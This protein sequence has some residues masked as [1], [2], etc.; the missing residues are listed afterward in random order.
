MKK[1]SINKGSYP[2]L[3]S[4]CKNFG[5]L[6][7]WVEHEG[8]R[9]NLFVTSIT[10]N[11]RP[12]DADEESLLDRL[13]MSEVI[14]LDVQLQSIEELVVA[15]LENTIQLIQNLQLKAG[16]LARYIADNGDFQ[17][18]SL[19]EIFSL[20]RTLIDTLEEVFSSHAN[21]KLLLRHF[22]LWREAEKELSSILQCILQSFEIN[23]NAALGELLTDPFISALDAWDEVLQKELS[24][25]KRLTPYFSVEKEG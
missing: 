25:N 1:F 2:A 4:S 24:E 17:P 10:L 3:Y 22:S 18:R 13:A 21:G 5:E 12:I 15:T 19:K 16:E 23:N 11:D 6:M 20:S 14:Q 8:A 9:D 7:S